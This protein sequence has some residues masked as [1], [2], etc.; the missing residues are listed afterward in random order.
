M[1]DRADRQEVRLRLPVRESSV[2]RLHDGLDELWA[3]AGELSGRERLRFETAVVEVFANVVQHAFRSDPD[4]PAQDGRVLEVALS[5]SFGELEAR[6]TD[7]G[8][9]AE[10]DLSSATLP[11]PDSETGR[12]LA[13][14]LAAVDDLTYARS[15]GRNHWRLLVR[16][17]AP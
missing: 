8:R 16:V 6:F 17:A 13:M 4:V 1:T 11:D 9:P 2:D 3:R 15:G 10:L 14:A 7:N 5:A 12:G